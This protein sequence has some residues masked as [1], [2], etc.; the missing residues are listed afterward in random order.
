M[1]ERVAGIAKPVL[2]SPKQQLLKS[3]CSVCGDLLLL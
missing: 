3:S 2:M 1:D